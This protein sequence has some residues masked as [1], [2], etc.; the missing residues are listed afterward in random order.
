MFNWFA[1]AWL[2][3]ALCLRY[4]SISVLLYP[5]KIS[6]PSANDVL[7]K[8]HKAHSLPGA[9]ANICQRPSEVGAKCCLS[10][11]SERV[12][13]WVA[14]KISTEATTQIRGS[15]FVYK[16]EAKII[17]NWQ[18]EIKCEKICRGI[19]NKS[20]YTQWN[21]NLYFKITRT[22]SNIIS[23]YTGLDYL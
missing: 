16:Q 14:I 20:V 22:F 18:R 17:V 5:P 8:R 15:F 11:P 3:L 13:E 6:V 4:S 2:L 1:F 21:S 23:I 12:S 19:R 10:I 7:N 9:Y